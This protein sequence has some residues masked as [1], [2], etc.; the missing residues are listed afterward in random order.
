MW[1]TFVGTK[2]FKVLRTLAKTFVAAALGQLIVFGTG[3]LDLSGT[4][5]K[6]ILA[7]ALAAVI[8]VAYNSLN[9]SYSDYGI[10][11]VSEDDE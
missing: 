9:P 10:G 4:E 7:S 11:A 5:W 1:E 3:I 2:T 6:A 8:L